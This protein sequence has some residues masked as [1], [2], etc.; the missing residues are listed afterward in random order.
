MHSIMQQK[1]GCCYLCMLLHFDYGPKAIE[2]HHVSFGTANRALSEKYGL[3]VYLCPEH[4]R[5]GKESAHMNH[6]IARLLQQE[7]QEKF[8]LYNPDLSF[9]E[10]FGINYLG[11][12]SRQVA[13]AHGEAFEVKNG[14]K[15]I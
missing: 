7:A 12:K 5:T 2:E 13:A 4:H 11:D 1:D 8:E 14:F 15:F 3:K 9:L 10:I 6:D